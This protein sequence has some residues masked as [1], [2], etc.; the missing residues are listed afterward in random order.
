MF[1]AQ[2]TRAEARRLIVMLSL[3][4]ASALLLMGLSLL[5]W[6]S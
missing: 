2:T 1:D 4:A 6:M 5:G 3:Y